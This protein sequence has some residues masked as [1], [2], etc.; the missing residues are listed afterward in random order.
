MLE[1]IKA[2]LI[3]RYGERWLNGVNNQNGLAEDLSIL[4]KDITRVSRKFGLVGRGMFL[5]TESEVVARYEVIKPVSTLFDVD[6][7]FYGWWGHRASENISF[8]Q[9][10][11][12]DD[13]VIYHFIT[14]SPTHGHSGRI[15]LMGREVKNVIQ[16]R[17]ERRMKRLGGSSDSV[18]GET[19]SVDQSSN[20]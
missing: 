12:G 15:I 5:S 18:E 8:I 4:E 7:V 20:P 11:I 14:G 10:E 13:E 9:R 17:W 2:L 19:S 6:S 16:K 1:D 3:A